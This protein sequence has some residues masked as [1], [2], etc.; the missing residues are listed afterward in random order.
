MG[1]AQDA[2]EPSHYCLVG[3]G[4]RVYV[5]RWTLPLRTNSS[6]RKS[7]F[8][9]RISMPKSRMFMM[10]SCKHSITLA[11]IFS[12]S[13]LA[14]P[15]E[16]ASGKRI[17]LILS[18]YTP[19]S[20]VIEQSIKSRLSDF[21]VNTFIVEDCSNA[22]RIASDLNSERDIVAMVFWTDCSNYLR[23]L[24]D[25]ALTVPVVEITFSEGLG[26]TETPNRVTRIQRSRSRP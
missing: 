2:P 6:N 11:I 3:Y 19:D 1:R 13:L 7:P 17:A 8:L 9:N 22:Q 20:V 16:A 18:G 14:A 25:N 4:G 15:V 24:I 12:I 10:E 21:E 23:S 26:V 5:H